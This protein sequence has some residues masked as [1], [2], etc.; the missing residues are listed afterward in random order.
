MQ[1]GEEDLLASLL[2]ASAKRDQH[3]FAELY[4]LTAPRLNAV[5][6]RLAGSDASDVLQEA[7]V[8]IWHQAPKFDPGRGAAIHWMVA[9]ARNI[10]IDL[11]RSRARAYPRLYEIKEVPKAVEVDASVGMDVRRCLDLLEPQHAQ[12]ILMAYYAGYSHAEMARRLDKPLGTIK[13]W[14]RRGLAELDQCL[15][16]HGR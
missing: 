6:R 15:G 3:A 9:I 8:R 4:R 1:R 13:S 14:V 10:A 11:L 7:Y 12:V 5:A 16:S 2:V